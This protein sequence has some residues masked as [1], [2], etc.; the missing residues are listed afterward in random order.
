[1]ITQPYKLDL[2]PG[3]VP[4][5]VPVSQY[6]AGSRNIIFQLY[7]GGMVF[8]V[9]AGAVVT[10]D[11][12]KPDRKGFS[13]VVTASGSSV[14]VTVTEQMTAVAGE[15]ECQITIRKD[16]MVLGS[17]NFLLVVEQAALPDGADISETELNTFTQIANHAAVSAQAAQEVARTLDDKK[18]ALDKATAAADTARGDLQS[19]TTAGNTARTNLVNATNAGT[20]AKASLETAT[21]AANSA[22]DAL[23]QPTKDA[24]AAAAALDTANGAAEHNLEELNTSSAMAQKIPKVSPAVAGNFPVLTSPGTLIDSGKKPGDFADAGNVRK[25]HNM[26]RIPK[27]A[28]LNNYTTV[29]CY[30]A[31]DNTEAATIKNCPLSSAFIL[32]IYNSLGSNIANASGSPWSEFTQV[33]EFFT[34]HVARR[35]VHTG[36]DGIPSFDTWRWEN[37]PMVPGMEYS[38]T[39]RWNGNPVYTKLVN[40]GTLSGDTATYTIMNLSGISSV[41]RCEGAAGGCSLPYG[42]KGEYHYGYYSTDKTKIIFYYCGL[43]GTLYTRI[44]YLKS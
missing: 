37:P 20:T 26:T 39:E 36:D 21:N 18:A 43:S 28:D 30:C 41:I 23:E 13:Y 5:R 34:G 15:T 33:L 27:N 32:T 44:W 9:P 3:G 22:K 12:S 31:S 16:G 10:C 40:C 14:T 6:D 7:Y 8:S 1:M 35:L 25:L 19:A 24:Q 2:I 42:M 29:G 4:V 11:G 38:T 17:A